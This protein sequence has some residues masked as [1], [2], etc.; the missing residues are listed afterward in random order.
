[1]VDLS[2][3]ERPKDTGIDGKL[4]KEAVNINGSL[5]QLSHCIM[6]INKKA[7]NPNENVY[8]PFRNSMMTMVLR[9]SLGGNC[10]TKMVAT[11]SAKP[12]DVYESLT[13]CRFARSVSMI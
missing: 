9:D 12:E 3:S 6:A 8:L 10:R 4:F 5:L 7:R 11:I 1:M 13:T 2:G